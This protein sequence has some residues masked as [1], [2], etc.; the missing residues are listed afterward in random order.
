MAGRP[1]N[2]P[3]NYFAFGFQADKDT[4]A[5]TFTFLRHL[6]G[7][8]ADFEEEVESVREGGDGQ[9]VGLRYKT[10]INWDGSFVQNYRP[11]AGHR[12]AVAALGADE[13]SVPS[14]DFAAASGAANVHTALPTVTV[15]PLTVEQRWADVV[16]RGV[17][18]RTT[19]LTIEW[20]QG[21]PFKLTNEFL[22]GGTVS[23][24]AVASAQ[25]PVRETGQPFF[26]PGASTTLTGASG[27]KMTKA[28]I[29][30]NRN[31]DG[32]IR[33]NAL[34]RE[35]V[36]ALN[37]DATLEGTLKYEDAELYDKVHYL[38]GSQVPVDLATGALTIHSR[39]GAGADIRFAEIGMG[40]FHFTQAR[41]NKLE[42][43]GQTMYIDFTAETYKGAT[44]SVWVR[45]L[46]ASAPAIV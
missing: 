21:R 10:A 37:R 40:Q 41:V 6:D 44:H 22:T 8:G 29:V 2:E 25:T 7:T 3:N 1:T 13:V 28:Q 36:V 27:A 9:E 12:S 45:T 38:G 16:E 39:F 34:N 42:P 14:G 26:Y 11:E 31:L 19:S 43:D 5:T 4:E 46:I 17:N 30:L 23:R 24:R 15:P 20:E 18:V 33:T 32:D 35:D